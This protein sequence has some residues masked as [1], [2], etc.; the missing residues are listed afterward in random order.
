MIKR[1]AGATVAAF[2]LVL[3]FA[4]PGTAAQPRPGLYEQQRADGTTKIALN[5]DSYHHVSP[6]VSNRCVA[7]AVPLTLKVNSAGRFSFHGSAK[8]VAGRRVL[9]DLT[10]TFISRKV[11]TGKAHYRTARCSAPAFRY[12]ATF[13]APTG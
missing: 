8:N 11:V 6:E 1:C 12:R 9:V 7:R 2:S 3:A 13:V 5:V 10:G 4:Q